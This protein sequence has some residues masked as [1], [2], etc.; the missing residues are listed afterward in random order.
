MR[1]RTHTHTHHTHVPTP[2]SSV[3]FG[4]LV[5][6]DGYHHDPVLEYPHHP[7][8]RSVLIFMLILVT[9][10]L[11]FISLDLSFLNILNIW[12]PKLQSLLPQ[13]PAF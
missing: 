7:A 5:K 1:A 2:C 3:I 10:S 11:L 4:K 12:S 6:L 13:A 8:Q 9:T